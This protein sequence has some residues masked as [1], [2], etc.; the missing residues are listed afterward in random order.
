MI[1][2]RSSNFKVGENAKLNQENFTKTSGQISQSSAKPSLQK[3]KAKLLPPEFIA[4]P[5][6]T[7][8]LFFKLQHNLHHT[9]PLST[10]EHQLPISDKILNSPTSSFIPCM[11]LPHLQSTKLLIYLHG[12]GEDVQVS[13]RQLVVMRAKMQVSILAVEY[14]R[15]EA[16]YIEE[17]RTACK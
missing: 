9:L 14:P 1:S 17:S 10:I 6:R 12:N 5:R 8:P 7:S 11:L 4:L 15:Y 13:R 3:K 2:V 16:G